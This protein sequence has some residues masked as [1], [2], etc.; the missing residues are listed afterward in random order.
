MNIFVPNDEDKSYK[1]KNDSVAFSMTKVMLWMGLGLLITGIIGFALPDLLMLIINKSGMSTSG[2]NTMLTTIDIISSILMVVSMIYI[3]IKSFGHKSSM[4]VFFYV[5]FA[6][7]MGV[8]L[9]SILLQVLAISMA[10]DVSFISTVS[11]AFLITAGSFLLMGLIGGLT[12]RNL[13]VLWPLLMSIVFGAAI[14]SLVNFFMG[15]STIYWITDFVMLAVI[16]I[17]IAIDMN[18]VK[19]LAKVGAFSGE[20]NLAIYCAY[21]LYTDFILIFIRILS[22]VAMRRKD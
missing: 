6:I 17:I 12:K 7:T 20:N 19:K 16:L 11:I 13:S 9:S 22:Y 2:A 21:Q 14:L 15:S 5:L 3:N 1:V 10:N 18:R 4:M 8:T